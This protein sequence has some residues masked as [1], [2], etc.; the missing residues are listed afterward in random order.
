MVEESRKTTLPWER[1]VL[2]NG[3]KRL[4]TPVRL[5]V[6]RLPHVSNHGW[7]FLAGSPFRRRLGIY[8]CESLNEAC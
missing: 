1:E 2:Q 3:V 4:L 5:R 6:R 8:R 7:R